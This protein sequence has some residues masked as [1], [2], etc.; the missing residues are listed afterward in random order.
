MRAP[1]GEP[2]A[3]TLAFSFTIGATPFVWLCPRRVS[4]SAER[5]AGTGESIRLG[6]FEYRLSLLIS[7]MRLRSLLLQKG[8]GDSGC[9]GTDKKD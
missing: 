9:D 6:R 8:G 5:G 1:L 2:V 4:A 7:R 3:D